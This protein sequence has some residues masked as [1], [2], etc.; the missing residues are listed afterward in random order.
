V[1]A[2]DEIRGRIAARCR[3]PYRAIPLLSDCKD[4]KAMNDRF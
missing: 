1:T 3:D 4:P 2:I